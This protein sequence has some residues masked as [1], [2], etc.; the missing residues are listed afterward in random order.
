MLLEDKVLLKPMSY[1]E[2]QKYRK[3]RNKEDIRDCFVYKD[4]I[5][6][7]AQYIWY[8]KYLKL[9]NDC[10]F[11]IYYDGMFVGGNAIYNINFEKKEAEYGRLL[12][13]QA[14]VK[15]KGLGKVVTKLACIIA[16]QSLGLKRLYLHVY[17]NNLP[18]IKVYKYV[19]FDLIREEGQGAEK[20]ICMEIWL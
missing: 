8:K 2:C 13:N 19:G 4:F 7:E 5:S 17:A 15:R 14:T 9:D 6:R 3:L 18:A 11:S 1:D 16:K 20:M 12:L 10:M